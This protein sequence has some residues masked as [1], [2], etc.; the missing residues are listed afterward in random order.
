MNTII[1]PILL[2]V[3]R[4]SLLLSYLWNSH[5]SCNWILKMSLEDLGQQAY[6]RAEV[7]GDHKGAVE[8]LNKAIGKYPDDERLYN[9]R[10]CGYLKL[11]LFEQAL[12]DATY[13]VRKFPNNVK[14][15]FRRGEA[16]LS[17]KKPMEAE[18]CFQEA[19]RL[20]PKNEEILQKLRDV[21]TDRLKCFNGKQWHIWHVHKAIALAEFDMKIA[22]H[23]LE[24]GAVESE[25]DFEIYYSDEEEEVPSKP[26]TRYVTRPNDPLSDPRNI[27]NSPS[28]WIGNVTTKYT[29]AHLRKVFSEYGKIKSLFLQHKNFCCFV[30]YFEPAMA[31]KAMKAFQSEKCPDKNL[32]VKFPDSAKKQASLK[33]DDDSF[34]KTPA[35]DMKSSTGAIKKNSN[36]SLVT[37]VPATASGMKPAT[38]AIKKN[39]NQSLVTTVPATASG[40]KPASGAIKMNSNQSLVR[41]VPAPSTDMKPST[42]A[43]KK[44]S[45]QSLVRTV[46][47]TA[48]DMKPAT[49]AVKKNSNQNLVRNVSATATG[50]KPATGAIKKNSNQGLVRTLPA[51]TTNTQ[52]YVQ[53]LENKHFETFHS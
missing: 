33:P 30:N 37:T 24:N 5:I 25:A 9:N 11:G 2:F 46:P 28:V 26:P 39:S 19:R 31:T 16:L 10:S 44:N 32:I 35:S 22:A 49:G 7:F 40:M 17:M 18:K 42:G 14:S 41:T 51:G 36:Q 4:T 6:Q 15:H 3:V 23:L 12:A 45:N 27:Y 21:Q 50:M 38:G 1:V 20:D 29:E 52:S 13:M 43:I 47:A 8:I 34:I 53:I 48:T